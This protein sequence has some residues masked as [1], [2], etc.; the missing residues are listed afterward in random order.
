M[1]RAAEKEVDDGPECRIVAAH[2]HGRDPLEWYSGQI[3]QS[4]GSSEFPRQK[5]R[6]STEIS[7]WTG[8][9]YL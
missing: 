5:T 3:V 2:H 4:G 9:L 8:F 1:P 6:P 7:W